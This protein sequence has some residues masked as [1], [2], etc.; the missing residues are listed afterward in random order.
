[1]E[2]ERTKEALELVQRKHTL[3][4][5]EGERDRA[6]TLQRFESPRGMGQ[7][8]GVHDNSSFDSCSS[9]LAFDTDEA[10]SASSKMVKDVGEAMS[11]SSWTALA[12]GKE[13]GWWNIDLE[14]EMEKLE[15][16]GPWSG[17][18]GGSVD[19]KGKMDH[20]SAWA[21]A[22]REESDKLKEAEME[23]DGEV[24]QEESA[25]IQSPK[26]KMIQVE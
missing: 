4:K 3:I 17:T 25:E 13:R 1:M 6:R 14:G 7:S 10:M 21:N 9:S 26:R 15:I 18:E 11:E 16:T 19:P 2:E 20:R 22:T 12:K 5:W 8:F 24:L 23:V